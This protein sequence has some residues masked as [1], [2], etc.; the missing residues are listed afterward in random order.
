ML[1][2][3]HPDDD[4]P[5][6]QLIRS[7]PDGRA[8]G[9]RLQRKYADRVTGVSARGRRARGAMRPF[10]DDLPAASPPHCARAA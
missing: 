2:L 4:E 8:L 9:E 6:H 10:P 3:R 5:T 1:A 7:T